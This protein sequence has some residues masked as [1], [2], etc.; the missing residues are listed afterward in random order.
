MFKMLDDIAIADAAFEVT[1]PTISILFKE[2]ACAVT[3]IMVNSKSLSSKITK[4]VSL[5]N[6]DISRLLYDW[7]DEIIYMK[8]AKSLLFKKFNV[9]VTK[10]G[11]YLLDASLDGEKINRKRHE[12]KNDIKAI[13]MHMFEVRKKGKNWYCR[14][15]VDL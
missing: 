15:I 1:S 5:K 11:E 14:V 13:T 4:K 9:K 8:D 3:G 10:K 7:L 6:N 2:A 12:L